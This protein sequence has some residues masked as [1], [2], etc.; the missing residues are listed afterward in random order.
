MREGI[1]Q[2]NDETL[3]NETYDAICIPKETYRRRIDPTKQIKCDNAKILGHCNDERLMMSD[4][5]D[6]NQQHCTAVKDA[7]GACDGV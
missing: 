2:Y 1:E 6:G 4:E 5:R 7:C 3:F